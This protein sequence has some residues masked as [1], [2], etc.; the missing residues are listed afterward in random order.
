M[1]DPER[2]GIVRYEKL[3]GKVV[4]QNDHGNEQ[5]QQAQNAVATVENDIYNI[6]ERN[7][8]SADKGLLLGRS[9]SD[10]MVESCNE[11]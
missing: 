7:E 9:V 2:H 1:N 6:L 5:N 4:F 11:D 10:I 3:R 8:V